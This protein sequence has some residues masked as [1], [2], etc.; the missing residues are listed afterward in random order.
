MLR[1]CYPFCWANFAVPVCGRVLWVLVS[2]RGVRMS[3]SP[4]L[5][6]SLEEGQ[7]PRGPIAAA[8]A[9]RGSAGTLSLGE[10]HGERSRILGQEVQ[11]TCPFWLLTLWLLTFL[12]VYRARPLYT[13]QRENVS[14]AL[15]V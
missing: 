2:F 15:Y 14:P 7:L 1:H 10:G 13:V 9:G 11:K 6:R 8:L 4:F 3:W 5:S 12:A